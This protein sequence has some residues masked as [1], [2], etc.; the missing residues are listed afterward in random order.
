MHLQTYL[1]RFPYLMNSPELIKCVLFFWLM[2][3]HS[4]ISN[5]LPVVVVNS[6]TIVD[7]AVQHSVFVCFLGLQCLS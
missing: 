2:D 5:Q 1:L 7:E 4:D 3:Y 6:S